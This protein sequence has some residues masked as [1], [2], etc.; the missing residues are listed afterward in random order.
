MPVG[1]KVAVVQHPPVML[2]RRATLDRAV[3]LVAEAAGSGAR[4]VVFPE[5]FIPGYP[6]WVWRVS[7]GNYELSGELF[8]LLQTQ[9]IDLVAGDLLPLQ[10]AARRHDLTIVGGIH[11]RDGSFSRSTL[12]NTIVTIGSDGTLLNRHRKLMPTNPERMVWGTGDGS[13]LR[14]V[15]T[16]VGRVGALICW[17]NYMPLARYALY[18][19]G[20]EI[21]VASTWDEG[22]GWLASMR[23][24][25]REGR[26]WVLG[27]SNCIRARDVPATLPWRT[28]LYPD[29][30]EW[31]NSGGSVI[32]DPSGKIVAG[33]LVEAYGTLYADCDPTVARA[34]RR[35]LDVAG[36]YARPDVFTLRV[37]R[38]PLTPAQ[39]EPDDGAHTDP[40]PATR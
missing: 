4:L 36:H 20:V 21:Y 29:D 9:A 23:H 31:I 13:G 16:P 26:C 11:E 19:Q 37:N 10:E 25:A 5:T 6:E 3:A 33:P 18:A 1:P 32:V 35:T 30:D 7:P 2:D 12:Y 39:F 40:L 27:S 22:D 28:S 34:A 15:E 8:S 38:A 14:V 17:E 24:I